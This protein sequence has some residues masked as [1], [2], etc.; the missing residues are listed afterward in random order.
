MQEALLYFLLIFTP[1]AYGTVEIWSVTVLHA[2]SIAI[3][4]LWA[5]SMI[6]SG[7]I[8]LY[9]TPVDLFALILLF[10]AF[11]SIFF[12]V[13]PYASRI[14]IYKLINYVLIFYFVVNTFSERRKLFR[15]SWVIAVF[16]GLYA[17]TGLL[18]LID[19]SKGSRIF[20]PDIYSSFFTFVNHNHFAGYLE[21]I[22]LSCIGLAIAYNGIRRLL[23]ICLAVSA[24]AAIFFSL[25]RGGVISLLVGMLCLFALFSASSGRRKNLWL[26]SG[27]LVLAL[28]VM[29]W[30]GMG[31]VIERLQTLKDPFAAGKERLG[32]WKDIIDMI[33]ENPWFGTGI[34]TFSHAFPLFKSEHLS[35]LYYSH[36]HNDYLELTA[37]LGIAGI[38][39]AFLC[40]IVFFISVT[41]KLVAL[42]DKGL[43]AVGLGALSSC[44]AILV[45]S[46]TDFNFSIPSNAFLFFICSAIALIAS[47]PEKAALISRAISMKQGFAGYCII[48]LFC[49]MALINILPPFL[50]GYYLNKSIDHQ[51]SGNYDLA[52]ESLYRAI[53]IDSGNAEHPAAMGDIMAA[54]AVNAKETSEKED[55]LNKSVK[56]FNDAITANPVR[57]YYYTKK[58]FSLQRLGRLDEAGEAL[59]KAAHFAPQSPFTHYDTGTFFLSRGEADKAREEYG[60][61]LQLRSNFSYLPKILDDLWKFYPSYAELKPVVPE[62]AEYRRRFAYYLLSKGEKHAAFEEFSFAFRLEPSI[63]N[64]LSIITE[65]NNAKE[66]YKALE[67]GGE[68]IKQFGNEISLN[69]EIAITYENLDMNEKAIILYQ[70]ILNEDPKDISMYLRLSRILLKTNDNQHALETLQTALNYHPE[71][72]YLREQMALIY[73]RMGNHKKAIAIFQQLTKEKPKDA[74]LHITLSGIYSSMKDYSNA[75]GTIQTAIQL[76]PN[77]ARLIRQLA[78]IYETMG[79]NEKATIILQQLI[80]E[81]PKNVSI[82]ISLAQIYLNTGNLGNAV[83]VLKTALIFNPDNA[84]IYELLAN[85]YSGMGL[86][87]E[88]LDALNKAVLFDQK[89]ADYRF[90]LGIEYKK[91]GMLREAFDQWRKCLQIKP[92][93]KN[94]KV[95]LERNIIYQ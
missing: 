90:Q 92:D 14:Q 75:L 34:G 80:A 10:L 54:K 7:Q 4:A 81:D 25:S 13:Y 41:K 74:P 56:Y 94:C 8:K 40:I 68:Y 76:N 63:L 65:L 16:G 73:G 72:P 37:E 42:P 85:S 39:S 11:I 22:T 64:A 1:L 55:L 3:I 32:V 88:A 30:F 47:R 20:S 77:D 15:L 27:V 21:M 71:D 43:Q 9:R 79:N 2:V 26:I 84:T 78:S 18:L 33:A 38:I 23:L 57:G 82:Y 46:N 48:L 45:H 93:H 59:T 5:V 19:K 61:F 31:A 91:L 66:Y 87:K 67:A 83:N 24:A 50:G 51:K 69:K 89:N 12:S 62:I 6:R 60:K 86:H 29:A 52:A 49:S 70:Q 58:A 53:Q 35:S 95:F 17:F 44:F 28:S 36:A